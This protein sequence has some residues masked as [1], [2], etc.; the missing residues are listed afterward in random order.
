MGVTGSCRARSLG[1]ALVVLL[2]AAV[3]CQS[4]TVAQVN[5]PEQ[6]KSPFDAT[7]YVFDNFWPRPP[8]PWYFYF[9]A[10]VAVDSSDNIYVLDG[11]HLIIKMNNKGEVLGA[12]GVR[13]ETNP[14]S[15]AIDK[16]G[17]IYVLY[18]GGPNMVAE[19]D[20]KGE[21]LRCWGKSGAGDGEF[22]LYP[23]VADGIATDRAGNVYVVDSQN[24]RVQEFA[25]DGSF[26]TQWGS[27]GAADGQFD[28]PAGIA[29][30]DAGNIYVSDSGNDRVQKFDSGLH[31]SAKW[32]RTGTDDGQFTKP[33]AIAVDKMNNV[34][35]ADRGEAKNELDRIQKF[36]SQGNFVMA[37]GKAKNARRMDFDNV[38]G[39]ACDGAGNL[40]TTEAW[41]FFVRR[42][43][44]QGDFVDCWSTGSKEGGRVHWPY[45]AAM[46]PAGYLYLTDSGTDRILKYDTNGNYISHW[47]DTGLDFPV[48][49]TI[50][51]PG[52]VYIQNYGGHIRK[53]DLQGNFLSQWG[54]DGDG[55]G[56]FHFGNGCWLAADKQGNIYVADKE[57]HRIQ[58]FDADGKFL[59]KWGKKGDGDGEFNEPCGL[60][61]DKNTGC[62]YVAELSNCRIQKFDKDGRFLCKWG[63]KGDKAGEFM[64]MDG[65]L[66][67]TLDKAGNVFV[68]DRDNDRI[69]KF[70]SDGKFICAWGKFGDGEGEFA[71]PT[72]VVVDNDGNVYVLDTLNSR[73]QKFVPK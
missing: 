21:L 36:D 7:Q 12:L 10:G 25:A 1:I 61:V 57:N 15:V 64:P 39:I 32:G 60:A 67:I 47:K 42:C 26:I 6:R 34:Y 59:F 44:A 16:Q 8:Q 72:Q 58:K 24:H 4:E 54:K 62:V 23:S 63:S 46:D 73:I 14:M 48:G 5:T 45:G 49:I 29:I 11:M 35:V 33:G 53:Y 71:K 56:E 22:G 18:R 51:E 27:K 52:Y 3:A 19:Y 70:D 43:N 50:T 68:G 13:A 41:G 65:F 40:Y 28:T 38:A 9:P 55:D 2:A 20:R 69:Q 17:N 31:V 30:D 66:P 37:W